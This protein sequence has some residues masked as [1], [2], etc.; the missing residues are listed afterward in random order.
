[1][2]SLYKPNQS[3]LSTPTL[4]K[5]VLSSSESHTSSASNSTRIY[6]LSRLN[7]KHITTNKNKNNIS[8]TYGIQS[9]VTPQKQYYSVQ[10]TSTP[11]NLMPLN[12]TLTI[13][14]VKLNTTTKLPPA[15]K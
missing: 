11:T 12:V 6:I 2:G 10:A 1:M 13:S 15:G 3:K 5:P 7:N 4:K 14:S 9:C 8:N